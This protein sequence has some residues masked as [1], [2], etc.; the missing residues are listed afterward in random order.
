MK[1]IRLTDRIRIKCN[2]IE[3]VIAPLNKHQKAEIQSAFKTKDGKTEVDYEALALK[4]IQFSV[5]TVS[6]ITDYND[7]QYVVSFEH[8]MDILTEEC[9]MELLGVFSSTNITAAIS[10]AISQNLAPIEGVEFK[11]ESPKK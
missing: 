9:A 8:D 7:E 6:G 10:A 4:T 2:E 1:I 11:V 3:V 5:K